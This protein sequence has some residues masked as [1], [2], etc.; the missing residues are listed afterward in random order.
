MSGGLNEPFSPIEDVIL[1]EEDDTGSIPV[2]NVKGRSLPE[3][4]EKS[5]LALWQG[6][7]EIRTEYDRKD[8]E[9]NFI[10]PPSK[11]CSMTFTVLR[12]NSNPRFHRC[13][14][15]GPADL[16]E[17]RMEVVDG[18]KDHWVDLEDKRKWQY[19]YHERL[20]QYK[21]PGV[22]ETPSDTSKSFGLLYAVQEFPPI[23]QIQKM[24]EQLAKSP[25]TR[26]CQAV[27]WQPW[28]DMDSSDPPCLRNIWCRI[29]FDDDGEWYLNMNVSFRSRDGYMA[30]F[31]NADAFI[32]LMNY[33]AL[34][35][36]SIAKRPVHLGRYCDQSDSYHIYGKDHG[37]FEREFLAGVNNKTF[38]ERTYVAEFFAP[39]MK[40]AVPGILEKI[41]KHDSNE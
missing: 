12:P 31:M 10:D 16:Q 37:R 3:A 15:G 7:R 4:W 25:Y 2:L 40:E 21:L 8:K 6:G 39:M 32:H 22:A 26:R 36:G 35:V 38:E 27:T 14:P 33:I 5:L 11:D 17:Y 9:G 24:I 19:T 29:L 30:A 34:C 41:R 28:H 20:R 1:P 13:F 23:D 18:I